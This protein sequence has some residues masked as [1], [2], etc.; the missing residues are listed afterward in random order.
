MIE[1]A[2]EASLLDVLANRM[3]YAGKLLVVDT[4]ASYYAEQSMDYTGT[5]STNAYMYW[6]AE[7][8]FDVE[9]YEEEGTTYVF[10]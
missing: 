8:A 2:V 5:A 3:A 6:D 10:V 4:T 1:E 9:S 7:T